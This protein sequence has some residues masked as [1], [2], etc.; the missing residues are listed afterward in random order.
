MEVHIKRILLPL[1]LLCACTV[2]SEYDRA[3]S[4]SGGFDSEAAS[5]ETTAGDADD[6]T[7][8][9]SGDETTGG[10]TGGETTDASDATTTGED[11]TGEVSVC[12]VFSY[13]AP[14]IKPEIMFV[15]DR[16][17]SMVS[18]A[19]ESYG[20]EDDG[21][22][23]WAQLYAV[24]EDMTGSLEG[25][26]RFGVTTFPS[27][28][29][30]PDVAGSECQVDDA[31]AVG[32]DNSE[33]GAILD[34][35]PTAFAV[36]FYGASPMAD[37]ISLAAEALLASDSGAPRAI[38]LIT[39][40]AANCTLDGDVWN[41]HDTTVP[42]LLSS[43]YEEHQIET[44]V[45]GLGVAEGAYGIPAVNNYSALSK[46]AV[47]GGQPKDV[48]E[49]FFLRGDGDA[50]EAVIAE[51]ARVARCTIT[52]SS[53]DTSRQRFTLDGAPIVEVESCAQGSGFR[54]ADGEVGTIELCQD[55]CAQFVAGQEL[56]A[57]LL[58]E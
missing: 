3:S 22:S 52:L 41:D 40:G 57:E 45:V 58:C 39:D 16:S 21:D 17:S 27:T 4:L 9:A 35:I 43:L 50:L 34:A 13:T 7:S 30:D 15:L 46:L 24:V 48:D 6:A 10:S 38:V 53:A 12:E 55:A 47:A 11:T 1:A 2:E 20:V 23:K 28:Q 36:G 31:P 18:D 19:P 29:G 33:S 25:A 54:V 37:A 49:A 14:D 51:E 8:D 32:L 44:F 42:G 56:G 26:A 5:G